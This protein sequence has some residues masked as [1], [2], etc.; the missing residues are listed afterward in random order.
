MFARIR[1]Q[2]TLWYVA[3]LLAIVAIVSGTAYVLLSRALDAQVDD[4]LR[5]SALNIA[6]QV[7]ER[8]EAQ[9]QSP[10]SGPGS[11]DDRDRRDGD[12]DSDNSGP[13]SE[14]SGRGS[15]DD[16]EE[17]GEY[18][19]LE[20]F[21]GAGDAFFYLLLSR[22]GSVL[23][24]PLNVPV[25]DFVDLAAVHEA[26]DDG[27][28][29]RTVGSGDDAT[30]VLYV[31]TGGGGG[32]AAIVQVGRSLGRHQ[33]QL[34]DLLVVLLA[35]GAGGLALASAGGF[36]LAGWALRP[37]REAMDR[38]RQFVSDASHE[39]RTPLTLIR[40]SAEAVQGGS[41]GH[42]ETADRASLDDI[43]AESDRMAGLVDE[44]LTLAKLEEGRLD[45]V[46]SDADGAELIAGAA[47]SAELLAGDAITVRA[48]TDGP[49]PVRCD[50]AR[51][52]QVLRI[53]LDN[54][55]RHTPAGGTVTLGVQRA[56]DSVEFHVQD[57]GPGIAREH[58]ERVFERFY[59][60]DGPRSRS[61][62]GSGLGLS[63]ARRI[64]EAHGGNI[65]AQSGGDVAGTRIV[66][67]LPR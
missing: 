53:L 54:A 26:R 28:A 9:P 61:E 22:D 1:L 21:S 32:S 20:Y 30:R 45:I 33:D 43:V 41:A 58:L 48:E 49:V 64:V 4:S 12:G 6:A 3:V 38:Q 46:R 27:E 63:I 42:L 59:R 47:R 18:E 40:A 67:S 10:N 23:L 31:A 29:W 56:G 15:D 2:L 11:G 19:G 14:N 55:V 39:L 44:L 66:F 60:V 51:I 52:G 13:G 37:T 62:G 25:L 17:E 50:P 16:G 5:A 65:E 35:T 24:N 57:S 34:N 36:L 8:G 7:V